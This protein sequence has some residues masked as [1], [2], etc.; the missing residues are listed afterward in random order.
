MAWGY[1][2]MFRLTKDPTYEEK[3]R[4]CLQWLDENKA[5]NYEGHSWG[6]HFEFSSRSGRTPK[7]EPII[8][9]TSLIGQA[10]LDGYE[11][12]GEERYLEVA[13]SICRWIL[14]LPRERTDHGTCL[15]YVAYMQS[16]VHNSNMLGA[17]MLARTARITGAKE[18]AE[19]AAEAMEYSCTRQLS[20]GAWYYGEDPK[21]HWV[22]NFHTGY[23]LDSLKCYLE[24]TNDMRF[25]K[26][27]RRGFE[28]YM[29]EF[30]ESDGTPRYYN[31]KKFP[32]DIQCASQAITTLANF[33]DV[34]PEA[35]DI[36]LKVANWTID[37]MQ[38]KKGY[39]YYRVMPWGKM[40]VP[41]LHWGQATM[42]R[43][44]TL[45]YSKLKDPNSGKAK[46]EAVS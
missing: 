29:K 37:N 27:L 21:Y 35:L 38:D 36:S 12:L 34:Y 8:V 19:T 15:S 13:K 33:A 39:F 30:F 9:W 10:F 44:L 31:N 24:N 16:T 28:Y 45:L 41:L 7:L 40:K 46:T 6:N 5:K 22:D 25:D 4:G 1:L 14:A 20:D 18:L 43:G 3:T 11:L 2:T 23:N 26:N 42:Y 17:A 32:V